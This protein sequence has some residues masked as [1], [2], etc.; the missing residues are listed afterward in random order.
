MSFRWPSKSPNETL[1]YSIDWSR[2][3]EDGVSISTVNYTIEYDNQPTLPFGVGVTAYGLTNQATSISDKV[4]VIYLS[5]GTLNR[6]YK[7]I[8]RVTDTLSRITERSVTISIRE[9]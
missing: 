5:Q 8:C 7:I 1:D 9:R 6:Q 2:L 4:S 3:I